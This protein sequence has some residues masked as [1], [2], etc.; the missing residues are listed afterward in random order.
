VA[1]EG[2]VAPFTGEKMYQEGEEVAL[3]ALPAEGWSFS[4]WEGDDTGDDALLTFTINADTEVQAVFQVPLEVRVSPEDAGTVTLDPEGG[5]Y[6]AGTWVTLTADAADGYRFVEWRGDLS[7]SDYITAVEVES[8]M[9]IEAV[10]EASPPSIALLD[11]RTRVPWVV[12]FDMRLHDG[13]GHA[14]SEGVTADDFLIYEDGALLDYTETNQFV[15][16]GPAL[17]MKVMLVLDYTNSMRAASA[18]DDLIAAAGQFVYARNDAGEP[19]FTGTHSMGVIEFHDR[20][21]LGAGYGDVI[22]LTRTDA[23]GKARIVSAIPCENCRE[24]GLSRVWDAVDLALTRITEADSQQGEARAVVF[25][26]DGNDTTSE[27]TPESLAATAAAN[28]IMLYPIGFGD[29][30]QN[31]GVLQ[32]L[33]ELTGGM[34]YPAE[35]AASLQAV[36]ADIARDLHGQWN[37]TYITQTNS[38]GV[39]VR[40][41]FDWR[42]GAEFTYAFDAGAIAGDIHTGYVQVLERTYDPDADTTSFLLKAEYIP[43]NITYFRFIFGHSGATFSVQD[44]GGL[45]SG[46]QLV[47]LGDGD[48]ELGG[49]ELR[50]GAFGNIGLV[51]VPGEVAKLKVRHDNDNDVYRELW[52]QLGVTKRIE[53]EGSMWEPF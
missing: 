43:R 36:F 10:F 12:R 47:E 13:D 39:N 26:T 2:T 49:A 21:D 44:E 52:Q 11:S 6:D 38:G 37:L 30:E 25:L 28:D 8:G 29:V 3:R 7:G 51:T 4:R 5:L 22:P 50:Y 14:I 33:A 16:P 18:V 34:Y 20:T 9:D 35:S 24:H 42:L 46:W 15:T 27:V 1:G 32:S 41:E 17:P 23:E 19:V 40:V 31:E 48:F 45:T 53:F